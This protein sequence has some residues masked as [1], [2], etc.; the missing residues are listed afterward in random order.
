MKNYKK[1]CLITFLVF[2]AVM[3]FSSGYLLTASTLGIPAIRKGVYS[4]LTDEQKTEVKEKLKE[5]TDTGASREEI[6]KTL[7]EFYEENGIELPGKFKKCGFGKA[8]MQNV[9]KLTDE[10]RD[11]FR[12]KVKELR[13]QETESKVFRQKM[14]ELLQS[15][16]LDLPA[17][18]RRGPHSDNRYNRM[19]FLNQQLSEEQHQ[20]L[21]SKMKSLRES[22][23]SPQET[24]K[25]LLEE[26]GLE[27]P[28]MRNKI[29]PEQRAAIKQKVVEMENQGATRQEI[30]QTIREMRKNILREFGEDSPIDEDGNI[31]E[32]NSSGMVASNYP[33]PFN[34]ETTIQFTLKNPE[35]VQLRIYNVQ[36]QLIRTL[37]NEFLASGS[38]AVKWNGKN[39]FGNTVPS[40]IYFFQLK[41]KSG[42]LTQRMFMAK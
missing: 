27:K 41:T 19:A 13:E 39:Q 38:H 2:A 10:Q 4:Q 31:K 37:L 34:P 26:Y 29:T 28:E 11:E 18:M 7:K 15:C 5:L 22:K 40:G 17:R 30:Q 1:I 3:V 6:R 16:G 9:D 36:G 23:T 21:L 42:S 35:Q 25:Q 20:E 33:N 24:M 32:E 12:V 8:F 14:E